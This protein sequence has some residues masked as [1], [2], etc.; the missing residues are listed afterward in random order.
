M[1]AVGGYLYFRSELGIYG[2]GKNYDWT[3]L[4][5]QKRSILF[6]IHKM[7]ESSTQKFNNSAL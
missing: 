7:T 3:E 6:M 2:I 1:A 5:S 4:A